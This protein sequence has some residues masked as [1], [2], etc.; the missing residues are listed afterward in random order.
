MDELIGQNATILYFPL[1]H[2][3]TWGLLR[4]LMFS[5]LIGENRGKNVE[6]GN[7][8]Y[9]GR[10]AS[11]KK[12]IGKLEWGGVGGKLEKMGVKFLLC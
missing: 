9:S 6:T 8:Q 1:M 10:N 12:S 2:L 4:Y 11:C 5:F 7:V 3:N